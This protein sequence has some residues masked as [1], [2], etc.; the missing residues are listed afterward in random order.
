MLFIQ[1]EGCY[2][3]SCFPKRVRRERAKQFSFCRFQTVLTMVYN[4]QNYWVSGLFPSSGI[5]ENTTFRKQYQTM[6]KECFL[7]FYMNVE[8][9]LLKEE[10]KPQM[11]ENE[12]HKKIFWAK[13]DEVK[14]LWLCS[15]S[16]RYSPAFHRGGPVSIWGQVMWD[17]WW[18][19]WQW[20]RLPLST[21]VSPASFHSNCCTLF[22]FHPELVQKTQ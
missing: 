7:L 17:L 19:K 2:Q 5:L 6:E 15:N 21:S 16:D 3:L 8:L 4:T 1:F 13:K 20:D 9:R 14:A 11:C 12:V 10:H 18:A 22:Y